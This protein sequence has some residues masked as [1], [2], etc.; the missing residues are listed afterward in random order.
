MKEFIAALFVKLK[1][2]SDFA[3]AINGRVYS[4]V[5]AQEVFP[6]CWVEFTAD[7]PDEMLAGKPVIDRVE[8]TMHIYSQSE[9]ISEV[10]GIAAAAQKLLD[11]CQLSISGYTH[12]RTYRQSSQ[13][14]TYAADRIFECQIKYGCWFYK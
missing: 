6:Y 1:T 11:D 2:T 12:V 13:I 8:F 9:G 3:T 5:P 7:V 14:M 10:L 4:A